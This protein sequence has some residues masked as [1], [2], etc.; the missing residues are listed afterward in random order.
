MVKLA[1]FPALQNLRLSK[2]QRLTDKAIEN[3]AKSETIKEIFLKEN[4]NI[5]GAGLAG[6]AENKSLVRIA[7]FDL[8]KLS[9]KGL[10]HLKQIE[11]LEVLKLRIDE[12]RFSREHLL[13][14][15][16]LPRI[17]SISVSEVSELEDGLYRGLLNSLPMRSEPYEDEYLVEKD[18]SQ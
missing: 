13:S 18:K 5:T 8:D 17:K 12:K 10:G 16:G 3:L 7:L 11:A 14:L 15:Y 6:F 2:V 9:A 1:R 4:R